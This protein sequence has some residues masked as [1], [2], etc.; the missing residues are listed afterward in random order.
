MA[1][2]ILSGMGISRSESSMQSKE[3]LRTFCEMKIEGSSHDTFEGVRELPDGP[4]P[5]LRGLGSFDCVADRFA[6]STFAQDDR[7]IVT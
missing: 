4:L 5:G 7:T 1:F 6:D 3:P 2:V